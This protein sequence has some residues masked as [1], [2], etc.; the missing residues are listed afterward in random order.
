MTQ[1][2][3]K[4]D[5][6]S[7]RRVLV[8]GDI[9][10]EYAKLQAA[11]DALDFNPEVDALV[12]V[13]DLADRG[14]DSMAALDWLAKPWFHRVVGNHDVAP[15]WVLQGQLSRYDFR[16]WGGDWC[17]DLPDH[18]V[19]RVAALLEAAPVAMTV[20]TP[21]GH[22]VGVVHADCGRNWKDYLA[23][24]AVGSK[25]RTAT[26]DMSL[27]SRNT[28]RDIQQRMRDGLKVNPGW[29]R[30]KG[31][32]HVFHGHTILPKPLTV[33]NRSWIDTGAYKGGP[34]TVLDMDKWIAG[35]RDDIAD[36]STKTKDD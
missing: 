20:L 30:V 24:I 16:Q 17:M 18:E 36:T 35:H 10:G 33:A 9:H 15:R 1:P 14:T 23:D 7:R 29:A 3:L 6:T 11:L 8:V 32:D 12:S 22:K 34:M 31:I 26:T 21:G 13:G 19:E 28:I 4:L 25:R 5:L 2:H 27:F